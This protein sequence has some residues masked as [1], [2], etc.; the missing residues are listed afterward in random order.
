[1]SEEKTVQIGPT[2]AEL[3]RQREERLTALAAGAGDE[4]FGEGEDEEPNPAELLTPD[5]LKAV[6]PEAE[7]GE[8]APD[9]ETPAD[10]PAPEV[11]EPGPKPDPLQTVQA[12]ADRL[13]EKLTPP[14]PEPAPEPSEREILRTTLEARTKPEALA[15]ALTAEG[16]ADTKE[17]RKALRDILVAEAQR[18]DA[19]LVA[20]EAAAE[21]RAA[22]EELKELKL[23]T[24]MEPVL[25]KAAV[26]QLPPK[27]QALVKHYT[28]EYMGIGKTAAEAVELALEETGFKE[29]LS[30][31]NPAPAPSEA[32]RRGSPRAIAAQAVAGRAQPTA[33]AP[34]RKP[35]S[36]EEERQANILKLAR[37][38]F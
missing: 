25:E 34:R 20:K 31:K 13:A 33:T 3:E 29:I 18:M 12:F 23:Q 22:K 8:P 26:S 1:M 16:Y 2:E 27:A 32:Q 14:K 28:R 24:A 36:S 15:A 38:G 4:I 37:S 21:A 17:N 6:E 5:E 10:D 35:A 11:A 19:M 7:P 30:S 9:P